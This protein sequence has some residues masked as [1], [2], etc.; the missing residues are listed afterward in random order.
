MI[1]LLPL[2]F[3]QNKSIK[4]L[5]ADPIVHFNFIKVSI[6][7]QKIVLSQVGYSLVLYMI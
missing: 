2:P 7:L 6:S 1:N 4:P 5:A 3:L